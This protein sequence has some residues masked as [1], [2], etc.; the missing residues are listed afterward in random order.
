MQEGL[1]LVEKIRLPASLEFFEL[2]FPGG[3]DHFGRQPVG[4]RPDHRARA[5]HV[6]R[7]V[8]LKHPWVQA[9]EG[10]KDLNPESDRIQT[11][12]VFEDDADAVACLP[13]ENA[14][15]GHEGGG[16]ELHPGNWTVAQVLRQFVGV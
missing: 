3:D 2:L 14:R 10:A 4:D 15:I 12:A 13:R 7:R 16:L 5:D 8:E 6:Q 9:L 11:P 1:R